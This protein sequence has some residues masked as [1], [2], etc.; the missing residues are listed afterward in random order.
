MKYYDCIAIGIES[1]MALV[2]G[3]LNEDTDAQVA[4]VDKDEPWW[5]LPDQGLYPEQAFGLSGR[6]FASGTGGCVPWNSFGN[7]RC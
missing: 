7:H 1:A 2:Q 4:V 3:L 6:G 5:T